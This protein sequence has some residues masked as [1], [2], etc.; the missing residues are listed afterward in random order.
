MMLSPS[1]FPGVAR[2]GSR[3]QPLVSAERQWTTEVAAGIKMAIKRFAQTLFVVEERCRVERLV[4]QEVINAACIPLATALR[5]DIDDRAA[6]VSV[7][8]AV[9]V[10]KHLHLSNGVL[11]DR[12][13]QLV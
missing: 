9:V 3:K 5:N 8:R 7:L 6:V 13:A 11:V 2:E 10:T 12:H 4:T 1:G